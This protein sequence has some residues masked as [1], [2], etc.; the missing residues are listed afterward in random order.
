[1]FSF[2]NENLQ[3]IKDLEKKASHN[4]NIQN[5]TK[6]DSEYV[7]NNIISNENIISNAN[8]KTNIKK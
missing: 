8:D 3:P 5:F 2:F 4:F 7:K 6:Y 1:M